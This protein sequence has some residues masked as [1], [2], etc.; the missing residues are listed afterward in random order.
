MLPILLLVFVRKDHVEKVKSFEALSD[1]E[2][3]TVGNSLNS[4]YLSKVSQLVAL[5]HFLSLFEVL[6]TYP[7]C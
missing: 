6:I 1:A 7:D 3:E 4:I 5:K 2:L